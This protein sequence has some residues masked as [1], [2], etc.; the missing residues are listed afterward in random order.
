MM[1]LSYS[2]MRTEV[3]IY[4]ERFNRLWYAGLTYLKGWSLSLEVVAVVT[5][6]SKFLRLTTEII[7]DIK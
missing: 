7:L 1:S 2:T 3:S 5:S 4:I 6:S